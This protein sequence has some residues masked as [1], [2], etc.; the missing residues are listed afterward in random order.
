MNKRWLTGISIAAVVG[1]VLCV[2]CSGLLAL[3]QPVVDA[4]DEFLGL[5]GQGKITEAY[6]CTGNGY[7]ALQDEASFTAG[8]KQLGLTDFSSVSWN[9]RKINNDDGSVE[10]TVTTRSGGTT[11]I[12][13]QLVKEGG[14]WKIVSVRYAGVALESIKAAPPPVPAEAEARQ[15]VME[16]LTDLHHAIKTKDFTEFYNK[17]SDTWKKDTTAEKLGKTFLAQDF[18]FDLDAI[19]N[20]TPTLSPAPAVNELGNLVVKGYFPGKPLPL[21]FKFTYVHEPAGWKLVGVHV[22]YEAN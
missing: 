2:G 19:K 11:P 17:L 7:H 5:L 3:T 12:A 9:S 6:A 21:Q 14:K 22:N 13:M 10:G 20:V 4:S 8:V 16:A 18:D 1:V 15:M